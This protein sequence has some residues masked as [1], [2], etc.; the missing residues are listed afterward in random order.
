[1][2][3]R[4]ELHTILTAPQCFKLH[5]PALNSTLL[6][7]LPLP[8]LPNSSHFS[9]SK[10]NPETEAQIP[11]QKAGLLTL[12]YSPRMHRNKKAIKSAAII[13]KKTEAVSQPTVHTSQLHSTT[14]RLHASSHRLSI[15]HMLS[16]DSGSL[17]KQPKATTT[18]TLA[19][20]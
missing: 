10:P 3:R 8:L 19:T 9:S 14:L 18:K 16:T 2:T 13:H 1:L 6:S 5:L 11:T 17:G 20:C 7:S 12:Y 4:L 15:I